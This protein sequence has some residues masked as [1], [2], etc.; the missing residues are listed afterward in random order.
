MTTHAA[1]WW[2]ALAIVSTFGAPS[3]AQAQHD[4]VM[5]MPAPI[6]MT[7]PAGRPVVTRRFLSVVRNGDP[8][9]SHPIQIAVSSDCPAGTIAA[10]PDFLPK[11]AAI[12]DVA[13]VAAGKIRMATTVLQVASNAFTSFNRFTPQRCTLTFSTDTP[14]PGNIDPTP[15]NNQ[16]T[17]ELNVIDRNDPE[18]VAVH[19]TFLPSIRVHHP[20]KVRLGRGTTTKVAT[21]RPE[22]ANGDLGE[23][24]GDLLSL[25]VDDGDCPPGSV[26]I[27]DFDR[28]TSGDQ[29]FAIV[30]GGSRR[31]GFLRVIID[32]SQFFSPG[33]T[34]PD[35]CT[36]LLTAVGP[37]GDTDASNNVSR[38]V[39]NVIDDNDF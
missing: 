5:I 26:G 12:D 4:S 18:Q 35:R 21:Y 6:T 33:H 34:I 17:V 11:T 15:R 14:I 25:V 3:G 30:P 23:L 2:F 16:V 37:G 19:E 22:I 36:A 27:A 9:G 24:P 31:R 1:R 10:A 38:L 7:I 20:K 39:I 29:N 28:A 32:G 13:T 8:T